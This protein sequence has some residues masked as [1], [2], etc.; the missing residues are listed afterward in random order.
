MY[1]GYILKEANIFQKWL[2]TPFSHLK[3]WAALFILLRE[4][5][6]QEKG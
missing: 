5:K 3:A 1:T 4:K 2:Y 6:V